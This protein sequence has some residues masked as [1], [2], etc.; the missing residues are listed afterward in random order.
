MTQF[1]PSNV[2]Y[3]QAVALLNEYKAFV[4]SQTDNTNPEEIMAK[5]KELLTRFNASVGHPL[6]R[7]EPIFMGE[8]PDSDKMNR[9]LQSFQDDTNILQNQAD[10]L[11]AA[12][13]Q[14]YNAT[15]TE[16]EK[17][18]NQNAQAANK[19][20]T[21]QLYS[22]A[23]TEDLTVFGDFF[24][25]NELV[26]FSKMPTN[27]AADFTHP[28]Q[29]TLGRTASSDNF[30]KKANVTILS[31]SNGF[32]G[33]NQE[34]EDP[35]TA[36]PLPGSDATEPVYTFKAQTRIS[37]AIVSILDGVPTTWL[38]YENNLVSDKDRIIAK[39]F[40]FQYKVDSSSEA[41]KSQI[42]IDYGVPDGTL[43]DWASGPE[44]GVLK[45]DLQFDFLLP[46]VINNINYVPFG[47]EDN[48]NYPVKIKS[49]MISTDETNWKTLSPSDV[50]VGTD[51]NLE[52]AR[53]ANN[54]S[55][56]GAV[57]TFEEQPVQYVRMS[58][59]QPK[60]IKSNIGHLYYV[61]KTKQVRTSEPDAATPGHIVVVTKTVGGDR[62]EGPIPETTRTNR[63][64]GPKNTVNGSLIQKTE[65]FPG[66]RWV[67]GIRDIN[68]EKVTYAETSTIVSK[69]FRINGV[70]DR[71][72]IEAQISVPDGFSSS[73]VWVKYYISPDN[74]LTWN[75]ISR[76]QDDYLGIPEIVAYNDPLPAEFRDS[77]ISYVKTASA[78]DT[79]RVKIELSRPPDMTSSSPV[80]YWYKLK[81]RRR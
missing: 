24:K 71:V 55:L 10:V 63:Y 48:S 16:I 76:I 29:V 30:L 44:F 27:M 81:V 69:P 45:L 32:P 38:E 19:V 23:N 41:N 12:A 56:N 1:S 47:L 11:Q 54:V 68:I 61:T 52:A 57:W 77:G 28:G 65:Y 5:L 64:F 15:K 67:I 39:N 40:N 36:A 4:Q 25:T 20:K 3:G 37:N 35:A 62:V 17:A 46:K 53:T 22:T 9:F 75:P 6:T 31:S 43:L 18:K 72:S 70:V 74:G 49:V 21:M 2:E 26:D 78:V 14:L 79:L 8:P 80:V 59:E 66:D 58:I 33:R 60:S 51:L 13:V 42:H 73:D 7:Y 50:W 34:I